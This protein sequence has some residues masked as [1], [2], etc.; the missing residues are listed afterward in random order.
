MGIEL[1]ML[2]PAES[3]AALRRHPL[4]CQFAL[5]TPRKEKQHEVYFD[6]PDRI[7]HAAHAS[8]SV[9]RNGRRTERI[10]T[11]KSADA[12]RPREWSANIGGDTPDPAVLRAA[13]KKN[14]PYGALV[15]DP[16][17]GK[18]LAPVFALYNTRS[19]WDLR[20]EHGGEL[21]LALDQGFIECGA[22]RQPVSE[23]ELTLKSGEPAQL[24]DFAL[25]L[26]QD[27]A[28]RSGMSDK[29]ERGYRLAAAEPPAAVKAA[30]LA[31]KKGMTVEQAFQAIAG[32]CLAQI[33][34]NQDGVA[35]GNDAESVHQMRVGLRRWKSAARS[36]QEVIQLPEGLQQE[37]AWLTGELGGARDWDVLAD[38]TL[39]AV[40]GELP[41]PGQLAELRNAASNIA[42]TR[43]LAAA[44]AI[45]SPRYARL[46]LNFA[47]WIQ[48]AGWR[49][50]PNQA[51]PEQLAGRIKPF[52]RRLL[53]RDRARLLKRGKK[54]AG[55][56]PA[57]RHRVRIAGKRTR[58][59]T[60]FFQSLFGTA[61]LRPYIKAL[62]TLQDELGWLNDAAVAAGL[63][64]ELSGA[65]RNLECSAEFVHGYLASRIHSEHRAVLKRWN[66]LAPVKLPL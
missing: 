15:R 53:L 39:P 41:D 32:N 24:F 47:R 26:Q 21:E 13:V 59:D 17:L 46:M 56:D 48:C 49:D 37:L 38:T 60:E 44:A 27:I 65:Q 8:L 35:A 2:V 42:G 18:Q 63:L 54:L 4:V 61:A 5:S 57:A 1:N 22:E 29:A 55:G 16:S 58:Y 12:Q 31:L 40:A 7:V 9:R 45:G 20:L 25:A 51:D 43:H 11:L 10:Q 62:Q 34:A 19:V 6:T 52:A 30:P 28:L 23:L 50:S 36:F 3:V 14:G 66:K 33:R 64:A